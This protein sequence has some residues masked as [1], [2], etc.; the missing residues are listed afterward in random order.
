M[1]N[2]RTESVRVRDREIHC[3]QVGALW[4]GCLL[5]PLCSFSCPGWLSCFSTGSATRLRLPAVPGIQLP[6]RAA[7]IT[8][9]A[10]F[11][12]WRP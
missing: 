2:H 5:G 11:L 7:L 10:G 6:S 12:C 9:R 1:G 3:L 4:D 8:F